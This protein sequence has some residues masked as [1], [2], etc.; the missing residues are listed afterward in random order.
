L[1]LE[2]LEDRT[3]PS[4]MA[5]VNYAVGTGPQAVVTADLN[6]DGHLD[7][8]TANAGSNNISVLLGNSNGTFGTAQTYATG[9]GPA[10]VAVGDFNGD[11]KLDIVTANEGDNTVSVLLGNGDG[12]FQ[13]AKSYAVGSQPVSVAVGDFDGKLDIV[14]ANQG[15]DTVSL[16]PG[17]GDGTFGAAKPIASYGQPAQSVAVGDFNGDGKLD[18]AVAL[19][20][21]DGYFGY[22][23]G[24]Y[25]GASPAVSVLLGNGN[26]AFPT[27]NY[28]P[29]PSPYEV[30]PSNFAPPSVTAADLN[31]DGNPDLVITDAGD[32]AVDVFM[33]NGNASFTGPASYNVVGGPNS[34]AVADLNG[35][36]KLDLVTTNGNTVSVQPGDGKGAFGNPYVFTAGSAPVSVAAGDFNSDGLNDVAV[37]NS[38]SNNVSVLIN[39]GYWPALQ[40]TATDPNT[41]A[42]I[43]SATA[44]QSFNVTVT[45]DDPFGNVLTGYADTV[46][47]STSDGQGTI[48]DPATGKSVALA[49]FTYTFTGADHG[50]HTF[51]VDLKT[52]TDLYF[53]IGAQF[54]DVSDPTVG[55]VPT[56]PSLTVYP[57]AVTR[58]VVSG[59]PSPAT[60][61]N[62]GNFTVAPYDA[63]GNL[64]YNYSGTAVFSSSDPQAKI[65]N[66]AT[67]NPAP[68]PG[69]TYTFTPGSPYAYYA[70]PSFSAALNTAGKNQSIAATDS[71]NSSATGTQSGIEVDP[72]LT[73]TGPSGSY[74]NQTVTLTL[75]TFGDPAG[76]IFTYTIN[77]G[78]GGVP[79]TVTGPSGTQVAHI[80]STARSY[81][82]AVS[83]TDA[84]GLTGN[85]SWSIQTVPMTVAIQTDP[86]QTTQQMLVITNT[87]TGDRSDA[88][89]LSSVANN[90]VALNV[91]GYNLG[92]IAPTN[93][94]PFA[95]V[96]VFAGSG[97]DD[98]IDA[99]NLAISSVLVGGAGSSYIYGGSARNLLIAGPGSG[100]M[101][102]GSAGDILIG[103]TT[104]YDGNA[105]AMA[106][107]MAEWDS[108]DSYS[109]R[110][111]KLSKRGG[112]LNGSYLLNGTTVSDN[113]VSDY[114]SGGVGM[115]WF[116]AH[117]KGRNNKDAVYGLT[118]GE[119][120]TNI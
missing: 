57:G 7:L 44:G 120:V 83:A 15:D 28:Y 61:G 98:T 29:L 1:L 13:A 113:G 68:L 48:V 114:L 69:F 95:L 33:N 96:M 62:Y 50:T 63:Y 16:L 20:G 80:Y 45:A 38:S 67:G 66:P 11:S 14:T 111:S 21:T 51:S 72:A 4:F 47:F 58:F 54:I 87:S 3:V 31:G 27:S 109:A 17:N 55:L 24:Y 92:T 86:A 100:R 75:V 12:T 56:G 23:G 46:A 64:A 49:G 94:K 26:G 6:G 76:T 42:P 25:S 19:R 73:I 97:Y 107:I 93:T 108:S 32:G 9:A 18:L 81:T 65:I 78:D 105:T 110:V 40:V 101:Y 41:G 34:I 116:F 71:A 89:S 119:V 102:A 115:D 106:Y 91:D 90:G 74:I 36:G 77:W 43:T 88:I 84:N 2:A 79:Q 70:P 82:I 104:S 59:F 103:G 37:A 99:R 22:Y 39:N 85:S 53:G 117:T 112:G 10:A 35:D 5:P 30:P 52:A 60:A 118:S 8:I